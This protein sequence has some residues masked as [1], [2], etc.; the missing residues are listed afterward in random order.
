MHLTCSDE[1]HSWF[2]DMIKLNFKA[3]GKGIGLLR[4]KEAKRA[5]Q[6]T[7]TLVYER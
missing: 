1:E 5:R 7:A 4:V 2:K 3:K 6:A